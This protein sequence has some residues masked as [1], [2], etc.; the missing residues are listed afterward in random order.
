MHVYADEPVQ[1]AGTRLL[2]PLVSLASLPQLAADL[3]IASLGLRRVGALSSTH[4]VPVL[5]ARDSVTPSFVGV[6]SPIELFQGAA[7]TLTLIL[8]RSPPLKV[9]RSACRQ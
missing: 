4:H 7:A 2:I 8:Q 3:L 6:V 5:G 1:L 9:R